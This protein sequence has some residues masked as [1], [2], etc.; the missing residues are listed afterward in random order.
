MASSRKPSRKTAAGRGGA[1]PQPEAPDKGAEGAEQPD[2]L[3]AGLSALRDAHGRHSRLFESL[4]GIDPSAERRTLF[5]LPTFE[6]LFDE[7]VARSLERL[8]AVQALAEL[9]ERLDAF[10][11]RLQRVERAR[12]PAPRAPAKRKKSGE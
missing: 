9:R 8:G 11:Q 5:K 2:L 4:L 6:D 10:E 7:R 12:D 3:K 1:R